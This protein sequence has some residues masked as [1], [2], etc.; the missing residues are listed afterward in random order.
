MK[1]DPIEQAADQLDKAAKNVRD[2]FNEGRHRTEA[3]L[4]RGSRDAMGDDLTPSQKAGSALNEAKHRV[5]AE[6][7]AGKRELR[8]KT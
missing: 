5:E 7:D 8:N 1:K 3:D 6:I 4:E 2:T